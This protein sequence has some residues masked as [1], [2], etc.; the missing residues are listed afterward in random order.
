MRILVVMDGPDAIHPATDT[1]LV[2]IEEALRRKHEV[3]ICLP[4]WIELDGAEPMA[5][6]GQVARADRARRPCLEVDYGQRRALA[7]YGAVLIRKDPP[8]DLD[9]FFATLLLDRARGKTL[10]VND[11]RGLRDANEKLYIFNFPEFIAPTRVTR[12]IEGLRRFLTEQGGEM[13]VKPL[14]GCGGAGVFH[15]RADDRNMNA[16]LETVSESGK[17]LVMAQRYLPAARE[18]DKR[19]LLLDGEPIG[20]VLRR[21]RADE[22]RG[23]LHVGG[24]AIKTVLTARERDICAQVGARCRADGLYFVGLDVIGDHLTEVN[25]TSPTG[26]QEIDRLD[27]VQLEAR[28]VDWLESRAIT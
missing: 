9:Y 7:E 18:G 22:T 17:K 14:D 26:V 10:L 5:S 15:V 21:P 16:I 2:I 20:A 3:E 27:G 19:I 25:V 28:I 13:I 6:V 4:Q 8:F 24:T 11:P 23:N 12:S 1:T